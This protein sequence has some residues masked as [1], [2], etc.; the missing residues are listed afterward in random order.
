MRG[1]ECRIM[2]LCQHSSVFSLPGE[3][4]KIKSTWVHRRREKKNLKCVFT[5][6]TA[7]FFNKLI[8]LNVPVLSR[9][10][11][12]I[13]CIPAV[14]PDQIELDTFGILSTRTFNIC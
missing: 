12:V 5:P 6:L 13:G 14:R 11:K 8:R 10:E 4:M 3:P 9:K 2:F 1:K 7:F